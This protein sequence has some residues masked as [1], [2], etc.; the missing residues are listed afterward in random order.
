MEKWKF[1]LQLSKK[2]DLPSYFS[3]GKSSMKIG[4]SYS[5][6]F[7]IQRLVWFHSFY[8]ATTFLRTIFFR[9]QEGNGMYQ[10]NY[11][12]VSNFFHS[13]HYFTMHAMVIIWKRRKATVHVSVLIYECISIESK[14]LCVTSFSMNYIPLS[15]CVEYS[16]HLTKINQKKGASKNFQWAPLLWVGRL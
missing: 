2:L 13:W 3:T 8:M 12:Q 14:K 5:R 7:C 11:S 15:L 1:V 10:L 9:I 16:L 4:Q 6:Q